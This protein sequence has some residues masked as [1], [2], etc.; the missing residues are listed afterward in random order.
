M[1]ACT[2]TASMA[3]HPAHL[4]LLLPLQRLHPQLKLGDGQLQAG[5]LLLVTLRGR[6]EGAG[7]SGARGYAK[8]VHPSP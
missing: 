3:W 6:G 5:V 7:G 8:A 2:V 4:C 1:A